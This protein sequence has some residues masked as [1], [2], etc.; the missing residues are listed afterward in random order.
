MFFLKR[1]SNDRYQNHDYCRSKSRYYLIAQGP[2]KAVERFTFFFRQTPVLFQK[3]S[4]F[5]AVEF[6]THFWIFLT[7]PPLKVCQC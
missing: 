6:V 2:F 4:S 7:G 1:L 3:Y 5:L